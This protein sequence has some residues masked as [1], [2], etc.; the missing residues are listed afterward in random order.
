MASAWRNLG[1][2]LNG[3]NSNN[4]PM[5]GSASKSINLQPK[6]QSNAQWLAISINGGG[7]A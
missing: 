3:E 5:A 1:L 7:S 4:K 2:G 6:R